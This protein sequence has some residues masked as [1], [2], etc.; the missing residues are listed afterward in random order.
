MT[1]DRQRISSHES[2]LAYIF[3][4]EKEIVRLRKLAGSDGELVA[5]SKA[6]LPKK[7]S[8]SIVG[9]NGEVGFIAPACNHL[10]TDGNIIGR[11][12]AFCSGTE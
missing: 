2:A 5:D 6:A 9:P 7:E 3:E 8:F 10:D 12:C 11:G 4:L 1:S